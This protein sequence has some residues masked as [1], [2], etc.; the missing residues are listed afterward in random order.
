[1]P[2]RF[3]Q[4]F[5]VLEQIGSGAMGTV[6]RARD[7]Q[8]E[9]E[10][11]IKIL[12]QASQ[13]ARDELESRRTINLR[14]DASRDDLL[15]E[16]RVMARL[17]HPNV[18][19]VYEVGI[20]GSDVF[21]VM[22][23]VA[24]CDLRE[25]LAGSRPVHEIAAALAQAGRGLAAAH[26]QGIVH[27]D[28]KPENVLI[29]RD[30]RARVA[31]FGLSNL[32]VPTASVMRVAELA[33]TPRYM[34]PEL[35][36][37]EPATIKSDVFAFCTVIRDALASD[38]GEL[39]EA[40]LA[41]S[42][43]KR[44]DVMAIVRALEAPRQP[45][46]RR[47]GFAVG[48]LAVAAI[49]TTAAF[50]L[51][52]GG[53][54]VACV[55][56]PALLAGRW[57]ASSHAAF[58][59]LLEPGQ[60]PALVATFERVVHRLDDQAALI[61]K[62]DR[63]LCVARQRGVVSES[64]RAIRRSCLER[65]AMALGSLVRAELA[66][67]KKSI[68]NTETAVEALRSPARCDELEV[69]A[70]SADRAPVAALYDRFA[71]AATTTELA[72]IEQAAA[73]LGEREL[74]S[75]AALAL[76]EKLRNEDAFAASDDALKR[77]HARAH[78]N[79][80]TDTEAVAMIER[81]ATADLHGDAK[82]GHSHAQIA[83]EL[84]TK[85]S[86]PIATRAKIYAQLGRSE[87]LRGNYATAIDELQRG[88]DLV[89]KSGD[90]LADTQISLQS[91][92]VY[93]LAN[94]GKAARAIELAGKSLDFIRA[95]AGDHSIA[96]GMALDAR[97]FAY[98]NNSQRAPALRDAREA[99]AVLGGVLPADH[100][101]VVTAR[102]ELGRELRED[103]QY[104]AA[105]EQ[106]EAALAAIERAPALRGLRAS[107]EASLA[108][109]LFDLGRYDDAIR[110]LAQ[111]VEQSTSVAGDDHPDTL[112]YRSSLADYHLEL[113]RLDDAAAD[114]EAL[115]RGYRSHPLAHDTRPTLLHGTYAAQLA[116]AR[117]RP[118]DAEQLAKLALAELSDLR[119]TEQERRLI[120]WTFAASLVAQRRFEEAH[121]PLLEASELSRKLG[122]FETYRVL[123]D[124]LLAQIEYGKGQHAAAIQR[125]QHVRE[126]LAR[127]RGQP[128][129]LRE[130]TEFLA[131]H[132]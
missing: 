73:R 63:E 20:D 40:G 26:E 95:N 38:R 49:G 128:K 29:G 10:V 35:W 65:T 57:D 100:S 3:I 19:P 72:A 83:L 48:A 23:L 4:R 75:R 46:R 52:S 32:V 69:P 28:F 1:V 85:P 5:E 18:V 79:R 115:E 45:R 78:D 77:A 125:A 130:V 54:Q 68:P 94:D 103:G 122:F 42:P 89:A 76:G 61:T 91:D 112:D 121:A 39:V 25:W 34:A 31:D 22:E 58:R 102:D 87:G 81:S 107:N 7:P 67:T 6:V 101:A 8:L 109:T 11:A 36:R 129:A 105:R 43:D 126:V 84:A 62:Q 41:D 131:K 97:A 96:Y 99:L 13:P 111:G 92:L 120:L 59:G 12:K 88:L 27:R 64:Q 119:G 127:G 123:D 90:K 53:D 14:D 114:I 82:L 16:A 104:D 70:L 2:G 80:D 9:R 60:T 66:A 110:H 116:I 124:L 93:A 86:T 33:G 56:D 132:R 71:V 44:P 51:T 50:A 21:V 117:G 47:L 106:F 37:G 108:A 74:E 113:G 24:G 30:G 98:R 55:D 15:H 118:R 17:A